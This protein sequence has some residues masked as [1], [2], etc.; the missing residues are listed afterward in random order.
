MN[1][2][3]VNDLIR[4]LMTVPDKAKSLPIYDIRGCRDGDVGG[5]QITLQD[6][7]RNKYIL[8][9]HKVGETMNDSFG[10]R[11]IGN[12]ARLIH[13]NDEGI[14]YTNFTLGSKNPCGC[15]S[16]CYHYEFDTRSN[17]VYGVCNACGKDIYVVDDMEKNKDIFQG[18]WAIK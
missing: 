9:P 16:N 3:T 13:Y 14:T 10:S 1:Y 15:D 17:K 7:K 18:T 8:I 11:G 4:I 5:F 12:D 2:I 6:G